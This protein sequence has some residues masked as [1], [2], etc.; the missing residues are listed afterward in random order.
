MVEWHCSLLVRAESHGAE[1]SILVERAMC[2]GLMKYMLSVTG[3]Q[4]LDF[5]RDRFSSSQVLQIVVLQW[6]SVYQYS[7]AC[8]DCLLKGAT[9]MGSQM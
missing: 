6:S 3:G 7:R 9:Q 5:D 2:H 4:G 8:V 1:V